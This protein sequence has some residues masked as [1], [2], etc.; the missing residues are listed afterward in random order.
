MQ[1]D[2]EFLATEKP[3]KLLLKLALPA[4][5]AQLVNMLYNIVDRMYIGRLEGIGTEALAGVGACMPVI[6]LVSA[7]AALAS[8]GGAPRA[9]I[10]MGQGDQESAERTMGNCMTLL[11]F[12]A[13]VLTAA[14]LIFQRPILLTFGALPETLPYALEYMNI[15]AIGT[16][17]VQAALGMNAFITAQG[18]SRTSMLTVLI[19]AVLNIGLDPLFMFTFDMGVKGAALATILSQAVSAAWVIWF[20]CGKR[21]VLRLRLRFM[22]PRPKL[23]LPCLAL[24]VSPFIMQATEAAINV[25]FN[26][27]LA[28]YGGALAVSAMTILASVMQFA[29]LPLQGLTQGAQPITSYNYGARNASRVRASFRAL[30]AACMIYAGALWLA[31]MLFPHGFAALFSTDEALI[32]FTAK[33]LRVYMAVGVLFGVQLACQQTF[34]ALG[35]AKSSLFLAVLRKIVLLIPLI[36]LLPA[37]LP[38]DK[39]MA[40]YLAE[41]VADFLAVTTTA[42][43]FAH[44]FPRAVR[45]L[46]TD[47]CTKT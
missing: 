13:A 1:R 7:F 17:F 32:D 25:C 39:T 3:S 2:S 31:V 5:T 43:L 4:V 27:Q 10:F 40:V 12:L 24:G 34:I 23:L 29:M 21:T 33:A 9:S 14:L 41:P 6:L 18:F 47:E 45:A 42:L 44:Q 16:V 8:M 35:N 36:Y 20:L 22:A 11:L 30:F 37:V 46:E 26:R 38:M 28:L 15:Y 19:G